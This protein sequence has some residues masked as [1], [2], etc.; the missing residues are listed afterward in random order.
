L[1]AVLDF[2]AAAPP[3]VLRA[4]D[5]VSISVMRRVLEP[6]GSAPPA[7]PASVRLAL[8]LGAT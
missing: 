7:T 4:F 2:F 1:S 6:P 3:D 8:E 5:L